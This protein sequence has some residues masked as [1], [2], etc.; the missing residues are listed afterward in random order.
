MLAMYRNG[1]NGV[2]YGFA[3]A[4]EDGPRLVYAAQG[5]GQGEQSMS[6]SLIGTLI[7][8]AGAFGLTAGFALGYIARSPQRK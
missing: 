1:Q 6:P 5:L 7:A 2:S 3:R 4:A 8:V